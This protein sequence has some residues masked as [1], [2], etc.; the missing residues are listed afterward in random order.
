MDERKFGTIYIGI[1][2]AR[3]ARHIYNLKQTD[4]TRQKNLGATL[5]CT[6]PPGHPARLRID[7]G[8]HTI[9]MCSCAGGDAVLRAA[10]LRD[11]KAVSQ[12]YMGLRKH[13][14]MRE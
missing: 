5:T 9:P 11:T 4:G 10:H 7:N 6:L 1:G 12:K 14:S 13:E 3:H 2:T 8:N